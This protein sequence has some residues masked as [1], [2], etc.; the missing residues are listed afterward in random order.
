M[1]P[2]LRRRCRFTPLVVVALLGARD[3]FAQDS[4][5]RQS[6]LTRPAPAS[7][8][9]S[10][11]AA[12]ALSAPSVDG[13]LD[14]AAWATAQRASDFVQQGPEPG[15]AATQRT[16]AR[17][18][19]TGDA[20]YVAMRMHD[21]APDSIVGTLARRDYVGFSDWAHVIVD[22]RRDRR[23]AF[24]FAVNPSGVKR[25]GF[26]MADSEWSEDYAWDAVWD[27][28]ARRDSAG[29]TA[30][31]RIPLS[32]LRFAASGE[33]GADWGIEFQRD[34][35]RR[36]ERTH[37]APVPASS[38]QFVSLFGTLSGVRTAS[39]KRRLELTPYAVARARSAN[40]DP[41]NPLHDVTSQDAM[42]GA[43]FKIGLTSDLTLT[44]T[45]NPDFGQVEADPSQV[46]LTGGETFFAERRPFFTEGSNLFQFNIGWGDWI[47]GGEQLFYSRRIGRTPQLDYPDSAD[48]TSA[49]E[50]T[51][52]LAAGKLSG[53]ALG[54]NV[55]VLSA[56][57]ARETGRYTHVGGTSRHTI[58]PLTHYG[59]YRFGRDFA[60]GR[61]SLGVIATSTHRQLDAS[62][63]DVAARVGVR[64]RR[65]GPS[66]FQ[67]GS[68]DFQREPLRKPRCG[69]RGGAG[70]DSDQLPPPLSA[71][72]GAHASRF[73]GDVAHGPFV[74]PAAHEESGHV[75]V[76][77][78]GE[79]RH[80][81][82]RRQRSRFHEQLQSRPHRW[83][84]GTRAHDADRAHSA[85]VVVREL[86]GAARHHRW[87][88]DGRGELVELGCLSRITGK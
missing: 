12:T 54:W 71:R 82:L 21:S 4:A 65:R 69:Q 78:R 22:S 20:I 81:R 88:R 8:S 63:V 6:A 48:F 41:G 30:E 52:L 67:Q 5:P 73:I 27:A 17:V 43:D 47:F 35:A 58:E 49:A 56:T 55:G 28:A 87:R 66:P 11:V 32:Q 7:T 24:R 77:L 1:S 79:G 10:V 29:W 86:V 31:F 68:L 16:D 62:S 60:A 80:A 46:N 40:T 36:A 42:F 59:V 51:R 25:D 39:V 37:W 44:G 23:T 13:R 64:G 2:H 83:M 9:R 85:L 61:G 38:G 19:V 26:I 45:V 15:A 76:R 75:A 57:T 18:V 84:G 34:L 33:A 50:P 70:R 74:Q 14:D 53:R 3:S 72:S